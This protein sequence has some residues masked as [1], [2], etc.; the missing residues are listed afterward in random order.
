MHK[1]APISPQNIRFRAPT[2]TA[3]CLHHTSGKIPAP[4]RAQ[5]PHRFGALPG[6]CDPPLLSLPPQE[7]EELCLD[8][9]RARAG[10]LF[11]C[12]R[13]PTVAHGPPGPGG[14]GL[15][16]V[17]PRGAPGGRAAADRARPGGPGDAA[18]R[19]GGPAAARRRAHCERRRV[20]VVTGGDGGGGGGGDGGPPGHG[21]GHGGGAARRSPQACEECC[22]PAGAV[23]TATSTR[24]SDAVR[25]GTALIATF[26]SSASTGGGGGGGGLLAVSSP[27]RR[28]G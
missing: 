20:V 21:P 15:G 14:D 18:M 3:Q 13:W 5:F 2:R 4:L 25:N 10:Q 17:A 7:E 11:P 23:I 1:P 8:F 9:Q 26:R 28:R 24:M 27:R 19:P 22:E 12:P 6:T 16:R